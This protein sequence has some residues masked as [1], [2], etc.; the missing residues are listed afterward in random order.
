MTDTLTDPTAQFVTEHIFELSYFGRLLEFAMTGR[1]RDPSGRMYTS[2]FTRVDESVLNDNGVF[3]RDYATWDP[4][5]TRTGSPINQIWQAFGW[6]GD[7]SHFVNAEG[8]FNSI[9]A[10]VWQGNNP[11]SDQTWRDHGYDRINDVT[12]TYAAISELT[13]V[14]SLLFPNHHDSTVE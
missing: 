6:D 4:I 1:N 7:P 11:V 9:K 12:R 8:A 5:A 3:Q 13:M 14:S 10:Q 2:D